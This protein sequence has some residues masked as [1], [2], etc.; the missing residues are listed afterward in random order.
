[1]VV[2]LAAGGIWIGSDVISFF[3]TAPPL[4]VRVESPAPAPA[5][6]DP[7]TL[8]VAAYLK[9]EYAFKLVDDLKRQGLDA[10]WTETTS[11]G[12]LWY[13]VRLSHFP[14]QQSAREYGRRLKI[15]GVID[16]FYVTHYAR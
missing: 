6:A 9:Q 12:K 7:F 16:D 2:G 4:E 8:Q 13:Q 10:Y 5:A 14:D 1:V 11:G 3:G 15:K